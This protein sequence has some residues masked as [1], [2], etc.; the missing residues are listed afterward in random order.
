MRRAIRRTNPLMRIPALPVIG[1]WL[2]RPTPSNNRLTLRLA[3]YDRAQ[4]T[5]E[6][7]E[8]TNRHALVPGSNLSFVRSLATGVGL[9]GGRHV[10]RVARTAARL[11][12]PALVVWGR[13]D[14]VFPPAY[15]K[16]AASL[17]PQSMLCMIDRCG[18]Y[19]HWERPEVFAAAV[20]GFL[21]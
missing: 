1:Q 8:I 21:P 7:L 14:R 15:A 2:G 10:D 9:L 20:E 18:H 12:R 13:Q 19:P 16:R 5:P 6:L 4:I 17:L 3:M 11:D